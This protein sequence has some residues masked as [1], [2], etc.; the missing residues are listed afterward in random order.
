MFAAG[1]EIKRHAIL[2][3]HQAGLPE[4]RVMSSCSALGSGGNDFSSEGTGRLLSAILN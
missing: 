3:A 1:P 2:S 4:G